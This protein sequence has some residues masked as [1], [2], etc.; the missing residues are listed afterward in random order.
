MIPHTAEEL[1]LASN[2][3]H[4]TMGAIL[5]G[6]AIVT[7]LQASGHFQAG[8]RRLV[9]PG[10]VLLAGGFLTAYLFFHHGLSLMPAMAQMIASDP[11]AQQ[12]VA[13]GLLLL[14]GGGVE[15]GRASEP[16]RRTS[17]HLVWPAAL[18]VIGILFVAHTQHGA[19]EA[20]MWSMWF[21]Q[22]L[23]GVFVAAG[24]L[25]AADTFAGNVR[26]PRYGYASLLLVLTAMLIS[27]REPPGASEDHPAV[28]TAEDRDGSARRTGGSDSRR[29]V[30]IRPHAVRSGLAATA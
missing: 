10:L 17:W 30:P 3:V 15:A 9:A 14:L 22:A 21:H 20:V 11:Q 19:H 29:T 4:W 13:I 18:G 2:A 6:V 24:L 28:R 26:W 27:Y 8:W 7:S 25:R 1:R 5:G 16:L 12:H 23:G